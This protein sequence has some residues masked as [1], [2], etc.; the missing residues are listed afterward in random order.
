MPIVL[1][2]MTEETYGAYLREHEEELPVVTG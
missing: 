1:R 2:K